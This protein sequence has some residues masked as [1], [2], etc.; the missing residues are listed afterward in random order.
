MLQMDVKKK[1][2]N[3]CVGTGKRW[4]KMY[5][6]GAYTE[7]KGYSNQTHSSPGRDH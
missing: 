2:V 3:R 5:S 6:N 7:E 1:V 4:K